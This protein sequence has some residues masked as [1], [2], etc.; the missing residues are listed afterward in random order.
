MESSRIPFLEEL[1]LFWKGSVIRKPN[2][3]R[4]SSD[5]SAQR[6]QFNTPLSR[7]LRSAAAQRQAVRQVMFVSSRGTERKDM[8]WILVITTICVPL[9]AMSCGAHGD[10]TSSSS[11]APIPAGQ[12][13]KKT[14][15]L[16]ASSPELEQRDQPVT[17]DDLRILLQADEIL[18]DESVWNRNDDRVCDDDESTG[19]RSLFCALQKACIDVLGKYDHRRVA[20]QEVRFAVEDAT[21]GRDF[22]HR[23]RDFNN[24]PETRLVDVKKVLRVATDRVKSRL[25][26][27][28]P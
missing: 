2:G 26:G 11:S 16:T 7:P 18:K 22:E 25:K 23:L 8:K 4:D 17:D 10:P 12:G 6:I 28:S 5:L 24:L 15:E 20:L 21:R 19:K 27:R 13:A 9:I 14:P 1:Q 3:R